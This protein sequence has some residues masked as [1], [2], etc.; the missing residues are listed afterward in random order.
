MLLYVSKYFSTFAPRFTIRGESERNL[1][2]KTNYNSMINNQFVLFRQVLQQEVLPTYSTSP[3]GKYVLL[4]SHIHAMIRIGMLREKDVL[5]NF[6]AFCRSLAD[7]LGD[8]Q[9]SRAK[10]YQRFFYPT[11]HQYDLT[12]K[13]YQAYTGTYEPLF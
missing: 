7:I 1:L 4:F 6:S 12:E 5:F 13:I 3:Y 9:F 8:Q 2:I 10:A 11:K